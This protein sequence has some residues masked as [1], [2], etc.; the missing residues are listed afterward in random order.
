MT[1][2]WRRLKSSNAALQ[3]ISMITL[4]AILLTV[5]FSVGPAGS[6]TA[7]SPATALH[8]VEREAHLLCAGLTRFV[9]NLR[10]VYDL[11]ALAETDAPGSRP[12]PSESSDAK[13]LLDIDLHSTSEPAPL[14][15]RSP[16]PP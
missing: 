2:M 15:G 8:T 13:A 5:G 4:G 12:G 9:N 16:A 3:G 6:G 10:L 11:R 1:T 14:A 7:P